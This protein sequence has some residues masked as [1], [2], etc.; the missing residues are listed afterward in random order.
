[1]RQRIQLWDNIK[2]L[3]IFCV[4]L[5]HL[6][7]DFT[8]VSDICKIIYL[9]VYA[10]HMPSFLFISGLFHKNEKIFPKIFFFISAGFA[11]KITLF[12]A[13]RAY[14][15]TP[16]FLLFSDA[17]LPWFMFVLA[18][19]AA[20]CYLFRHQNLWY[21]LIA[22]TVLACFAGYDETL[23][24]EWYLSRIIVFF[25]FYL[26]GHLIGS[27]AILRVKQHFSRLKILSVF[28]LLGWG[29]LCIAKL[30]QVYFLRLLFS[31]RHPFSDVL[32]EYGCFARLACYGISIAT[33]FAIVFLMPSKSLPFISKAGKQTLNVYF[34]HYPLYYLLNHFFHVSSLFSYGVAGKAAY[35][36]LA[37][38][39]T[40]LLSFGI[41]S[42]PLKQIKTVIDRIP[43]TG[44][45]HSVS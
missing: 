35:L 30:D 10:F 24:D 34:W 27:P 4:V 44:K 42:F 18:A 40:V 37:L 25:P 39:M 6:V 26:L 1:M 13:K 5:G 11:L 36:S 8:G 23:R 28:V 31:G 22:L 9:F 14:G 15:E 7:D 16:D 12:V 17:S 29:Y 2:F 33:C 3:L 21:L 32:E 45:E 41:F 38:L 20:L 19:C 43:S